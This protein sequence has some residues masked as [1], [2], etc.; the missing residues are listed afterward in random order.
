[1]SPLHAGG[2][3]Y[4]PSRCSAKLRRRVP[5]RPDVCSRRSG[6]NWEGGD[7]LSK[8]VGVDEMMLSEEDEVVR[9]TQRMRVLT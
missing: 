4:I 9:I 7:A 8:V 2:T 5:R 3:H 6:R 1:M